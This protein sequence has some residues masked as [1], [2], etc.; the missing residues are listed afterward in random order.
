VF[1]VVIFAMTLYKTLTRPRG[2][3]G[4]LAMI[5]RD[6]MY[7]LLVHFYCTV[8]EDLIITGTVYFG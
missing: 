7:K 8:V 4:L 1:D 3:F 5:M 6:G 2:S